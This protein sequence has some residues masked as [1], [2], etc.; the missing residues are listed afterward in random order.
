MDGG[1]C[2]I[3]VPSCQ[4]CSEPKTAMEK[5]NY[6]KKINYGNNKEI[7]G[8]REVEMNRQSTAGF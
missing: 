5:K 6:L 4:F 7:T 2:E 3:S 8:G 1:L